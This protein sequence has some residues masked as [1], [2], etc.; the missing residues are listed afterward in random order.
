MKIMNA[1]LL[2][3]TW[4]VQWDNI[5]WIGVLLLFVALM[6]DAVDYYQ[7]KE[8]NRERHGFFELQTTWAR[9]TAKW[10][11]FVGALV[12]VIAGTLANMSML[13]NDPATL[14]VGTICL[15][16]LQ[17]MLGAGAIILLCLLAKFCYHLS[18]LIYCIFVSIYKGLVDL[19]KW[20]I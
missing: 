4:G 6:L 14:I 7:A 20:L 18:I 19:C 16:G 12:L 9:H 17:I 13:H 1:L 3:I 10:S 11:F 8:E 2:L 15:I 5:Q